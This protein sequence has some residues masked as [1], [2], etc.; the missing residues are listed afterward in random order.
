LLAYLELPADQLINILAC[1]A[2]SHA[3]DVAQITAQPGFSLKR[4]GATLLSSAD[5]IHHCAISLI[6]RKP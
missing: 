3:S 5:S 6:K 2:L 4:P 1:T